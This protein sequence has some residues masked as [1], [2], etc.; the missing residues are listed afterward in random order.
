[1]SSKFVFSSGLV[2]VAL[3][4]AACGDAATGAYG[5]PAASPSTAPVV[6]PSASP[7]PVYPTPV[8]PTPMYP[9]PTV[10]VGTKIGV[11]S[12]RLGQILVDGKG[13]TLYLFVADSGTRSTCNSS[14]CVQYWPPVLTKGAPQAGAGVKGS[15]LG[16]TKRQDGTTEV[17][18]AGHPLYYFISDTKAGDVTGQGIDGFGGPWY[19]VSPSGM[20][21]R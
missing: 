17:T 2:A 20:Q 12:T 14:A 18:Y 19:V 3:F 15:L 7:A 5:V 21:I 4:A 10:A 6:A 16:T 13:R 9:T 1:M 8:Y 11:G